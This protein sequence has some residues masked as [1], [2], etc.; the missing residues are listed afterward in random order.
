VVC[1]EVPGRPVDALLHEAA[2]SGDPAAAAYCIERVAPVV[3]RLHDQG[4][5]HRDLYWNHF[6]A[7]SRS[8]PPSLIDVERAFRPRWRRRRWQVKD[9]ASLLASTPRGLS[10][11]APLRFL[12]AY[13]GGARDWKAWARAIARKAQRIRRHRPKYG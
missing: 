9:L 4:L 10:A 11:A 2:V 3:K 12:L 6:F 13:L 1:F 8:E 7:A 5:C